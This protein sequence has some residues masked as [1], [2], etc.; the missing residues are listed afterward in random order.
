M[1]DIERVHPK[2]QHRQYFKREHKTECEGNEYDH[3]TSYLLDGNEELG[4]V[5]AIAGQV[6][7]LEKE[8]YRQG[9]H[10]EGITRLNNED[11]DI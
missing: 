7:D 8:L 11:R 9:Y 6:P 5:D 2:V 1:L 3:E 10:E 4:E